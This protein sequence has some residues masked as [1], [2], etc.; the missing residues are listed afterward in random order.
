MTNFNALLFG[1]SYALLAAPASLLVRAGFKVDLICPH[2]QHV[3]TSQWVDISAPKNLLVSQAINL[4]GSKKYHLVIVGDDYCMADIVDSNLPIELKVKLL[5]VV[6]NENLEHLFSKCALS[7]ILLAAGISTPEFEICN[8]L[9]DLTEHAK[10]IGFPLFIKVDRSGGGCGVFECANNK[11]LLEKSTNL[12]YPLLLQRKIEGSIVDMSAF[13]QNG[14]LIDFSYS[15]F[16]KTVGGPFGA[17]SVRQYTQIAY[18]PIEVFIELERL[19]IALGAHGFANI[20]CMEDCITGQRYFIEA[21][22]RPNVW[23]DHSKYIGNDLAKAIGQYFLKGQ[24]LLLPLVINPLYPQ[25][26]LVSYADRLT[27]MDLMLNRYECWESFHSKKHALSYILARA[28]YRQQI[29]KILYESGTYHLDLIIRLLCSRY[30]KPHFPKTFWQS[31][32]I[33]YRRIFHRH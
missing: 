7:K 33:L 17:S 14:R 24:I 12:P 32:R 13:Y 21:D 23:A 30:L 28:G 19:G 26:K 20:T 5:P 11:E 9:G 31:M 6:S 2:H 3:K 4:L 18:L 16:Y 27:L 8:S 15:V 1:Y 10:K 25:S 29:L 22:M